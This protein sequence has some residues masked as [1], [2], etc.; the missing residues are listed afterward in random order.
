MA[1][2]VEGTITISPTSG[3]FPDATPL[4]ESSFVQGPA[5]TYGQIVG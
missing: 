1:R 5:S 2:F 3:F 4:L